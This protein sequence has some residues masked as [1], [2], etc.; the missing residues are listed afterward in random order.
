[1]NKYPHLSKVLKQQ[2]VYL[3]NFDDTQQKNSEKELEGWKA[4]Q[5]TLQEILTI[6]EDNQTKQKEKSDK[7][8]E[9]LDAKEKEEEEQRKEEEKQQKKL[10]AEKRVPPK[11]DLRGQ[12]KNFSA[13]QKA[14]DANMSR[15]TELPISQIKRL[16]QQGKTDEE[17]IADAKEKKQ[18][19][20]N[21]PKS[22]L[23][24]I[25]ENKEKKAK[26]D[27]RKR[28]KYLTNRVAQKIKRGVGSRI[29]PSWKESL[30]D[31]FTD[32]DPN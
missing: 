32:A 22:V 3:R 10:E 18:K 24:T 2:E 21:T 25:K 4:I 26:E 29:K 12:P 27:A 13:K 23:D 8:K 15:D 14:S 5:A 6:Q 16:R 28:K 30:K 1:M 7:E 11:Y 31:Y 9:A 19:E 17:I 20:E